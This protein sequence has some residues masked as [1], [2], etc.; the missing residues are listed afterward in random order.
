MTTD[1]TTSHENCLFLIISVNHPSI[2]IRYTMP[3]TLAFF[4]SLL[5]ASGALAHL[6]LAWPYALH[7]T[8]DPE[9]PEEIKDYSMTSPLL[10]DGT[11]PCKVSYN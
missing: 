1:F 6:Q 3:T 4:T 7:S 9:T 11:Y 8:L 5:A 10:T 2:F